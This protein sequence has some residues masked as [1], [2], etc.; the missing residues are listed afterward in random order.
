MERR[1]VLIMSYV[2]AGAFGINILFLMQYTRRLVAY[3]RGRHP[4]FIM[5]RHPEV[6]ESMGRPCFWFLNCRICVD[7]YILRGWGGLDDQELKTRVNRFY[8]MSLHCFGLGVLWALVAY[9][10]LQVSDFM[11]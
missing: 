5:V 9:S 8:T 11:P 10:S 1:Q 4:E 6:F 2:L 7:L 3:I